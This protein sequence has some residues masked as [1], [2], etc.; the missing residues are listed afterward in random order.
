MNA[1]IIRSSLLTWLV[2][3][4]FPVGA[5]TLWPFIIV[6]PNYES[7]R[8]IN[9]ER[10]HIQQQAEM[11]VLGFY[12]VYLWDWVRFLIKTKNPQQAYRLIRFEREAYANDTDMLYLE[13]RMQY[14]WLDYEP[15]NVG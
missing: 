11:W 3:W 13:G 1:I 10:I 9:H 2:S 12:A 7:E 4:F 6:N 15:E 8:L 5:I 14:A